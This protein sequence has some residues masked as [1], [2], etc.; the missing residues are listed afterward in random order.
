M[1]LQA[2]LLKKSYM[3]KIMT[4]N[5]FIINGSKSFGHSGGKLNDFLTQSMEEI[6]LSNNHSVKITKADNPY[7]TKEEVEKYLWADVIIYQFPLW[8]MSTPWVLKKYLDEVLTAGYGLLYKSDGRN[9]ENPAINY[10]KG[11]LLQTKKYMI[12][13]TANAPKEAFTLRDEF[14]EQKSVDELFFNLHKANQFL[15]M[16]PLPTFSCNDV[17]KNPTLNQD[18]VEL[19]KH[20]NTYI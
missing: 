6:L 16:T 20:L 2:S 1:I 13:L 7:N 17:M 8:W 5:I 18:L 10:G 4:K 11:G 14:F 19:K 12:S 9:Q 15:G 3:G